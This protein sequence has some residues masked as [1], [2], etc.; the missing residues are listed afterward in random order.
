[1][2]VIDLEKKFTSLTFIPHIVNDM[3]TSTQADKNRLNS[4]LMTHYDGDSLNIVPS[5]DCGAVTGG[6]N[7]GVQ[8]DVCLTKCEVITERP[9]ESLLWMRVPDGVH[10]FVNPIVWTILGHALTISKFNILEWIAIPSI[11]REVGTVIPKLRRFEELGWPRGMNALYENFDLYMNFFL[12]NERT[13]RPEKNKGEYIDFIKENRDKIFTRYLP[14]PSRVG[15]VVESNETGTYADKTITPAI[16]ALR[17]IVSINE[18]IRPLPLFR[19]EERVAKAIVE[20]ASFYKQF[21]TETAGGKYGLYRKHVYGGRVHFSGRAVISALS[22]NHHYD[23][24]YL[25]WS[26]S[27]QLFKVHL[28]AKLI[29][30]NFTYNQINSLLTQHTLTY[31]PLLDELFNEIIAE[32]PYKGVPVILQRNPSLK[33]GSAQ[34]FY[35]TQVKSDVNISTINISTLV[36]KA[37]NA[38]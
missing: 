13:G 15:F 1:M 38:D 25:P 31:N 28:T 2:E 11:T 18:K 17:I 10:A 7:Q 33:R 24:L 22:D 16:N 20:L 14:M 27:L 35:V 3:E 9:L 12:T 4:M 21:N 5:C 37:P 6:Y 30:R 29:R 34:L 8:C 32:S 26:L 23:E 36:L 19:K